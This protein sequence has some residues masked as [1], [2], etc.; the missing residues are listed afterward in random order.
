VTL[1]VSQ[2][3]DLMRQRASQA[4]GF[5]AVMIGA[6][7]LIGLWAGLPLLSSWGSGFPNMRPVGAL[8]L[9]ALGI[10]LIHPGK[11]SRVAFAVGLAAAALAALSLGLALLNVELGIDRWLVPQAAVSGPAGVSFRMANAA[12]L[13]FGLA[14]GALAFSR[15]ERYRF[16]ATILGNL[17]GAISVFALLGYLTGIDTLYGSA[18]V[19]SP[20]LPTAVGL[21]CV[22]GGIILRIGAM[23]ALRR[24]RP[25]WHLLIMLGCAIRASPDHPRLACRSP[26]TK[27]V[28][29]RDKRGLDDG[30]VTSPESLKEPQTPKRSRTKWLEHVR[31]RFNVSICANRA[32]SFEKIFRSRNGQG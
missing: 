28:D 12:T 5:V 30:E 20:P 21:L 23:P 10:A 11:A 13:A 14:G 25:L 19:S 26:A 1:F 6:A 32:M 15:F 22:A 31:Q 9:A 4:A 16:A 27:G 29:V 8:G 2:A 24:P 17:A 3:G 18:S 7:V